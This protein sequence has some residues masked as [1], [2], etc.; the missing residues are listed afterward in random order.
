MM[1][2]DSFFPN[3]YQPNNQ[4]A[5]APQ[6]QQQQQPLYF[7]NTATTDSQNSHNNHHIVDEF[8]CPMQSVSALDALQTDMGGIMTP[9]VPHHHPQF[10]HYDEYDYGTT[11]SS[12]EAAM[13]G[14][15]S[16]IAH[17]GMDEE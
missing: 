16:W 14:C 6:Q 9:G 12:S 11:S 3:P 17:M 4:E 5:E 8:G 7:N 10:Y 15:E 13:G 1:S 2:C